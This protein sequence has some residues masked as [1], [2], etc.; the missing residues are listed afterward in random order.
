MISHATWLFDLGNTRLKWA[1]ANALATDDAGASAHDAASPRAACAEVRAGDRA[2]IASVATPQRTQALESALI[3]R[4]AR[5]TR[6]VT[7]R[8]CA[9]VRIAYA[10]PARLGVD[11]FLALLAAH[12]R[13]RRSW[14]I[15]SIGTAL[16][17]DL[18]DANGVHYGGL[19]AP[20]PTLMREAL[21]ER[22]PHLP[23]TGGKVVDFADNTD[24]ALASGAI[25]TAR[26]LIVH[27]LRRARL[28]LGESP[29]LLITGG[30]ADA[31]CEG[32]RQRAQ[33]VPDLVLRGL[34]VYA[35]AMRA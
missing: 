17:I 14:L 5:I 30:G 15:A 27:S 25:G 32:W 7:R 35:S 9:G 21:A 22:A 2:W 20:S 26:A 33:R 34:Q 12:A 19:I 10:E 18:L 11:R 29:A 24:D 4:G 6:A 1:R 16:T 3:D 31:L 28:G 13:A 23:L 8:T